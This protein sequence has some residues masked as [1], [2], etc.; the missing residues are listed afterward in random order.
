MAN[1][2]KGFGA[3]AYRKKHQNEDVK[4]ISTV[5][6]K[7]TTVPD[8]STLKQPHRTAKNKRLI[9]DQRREEEQQN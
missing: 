1:F 3:E 9:E 6:N 4:E 2:F 5:G 7:G 8:P